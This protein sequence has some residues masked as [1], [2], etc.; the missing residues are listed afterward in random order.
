MAQKTSKHCTTQQFYT[1]AE[2]P[3]CLLGDS[4]RDSDDRLCGAVRRRCVPTGDGM[5]WQSVLHDQRHASRPKKVII[6]P[7]C[8]TGVKPLGKRS[9]RALNS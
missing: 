3:L 8:T 2:N 7:L 9:A 1:I 4:L 5:F 6:F